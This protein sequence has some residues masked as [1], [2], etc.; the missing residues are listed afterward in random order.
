[1]TNS[2]ALAKLDEFIAALPDWIGKNDDRDFDTAVVE[3]IRRLD[4][5]ERKRLFAALPSLLGPTQ[6]IH[7]QMLVATIG[8]QLNN[9]DLLDSTVHF[10]RGTLAGEALRDHLISL[11]RTCPTPT[12]VRYVRE[13]ADSLETARSANAVRLSARAAVFACLLETRENREA[14]LSRLLTWLRQTRRVTDE[15][16]GLIDLLHCR[17]AGAT[18][19]HSL[20]TADE[21]ERVLRLIRHRSSWS[22]PEGQP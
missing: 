19:L 1:M 3:W 10:A 16:L 6:P 22:A 7:R 11:V 17:T 4:D 15:I 13:L 8:C 18:D 9:E 14:S 5:A 2:D 20:F 12:L 21:I